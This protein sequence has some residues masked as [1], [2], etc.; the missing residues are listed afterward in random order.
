MKRRLCLHA[1]VAASLCLAVLP[2]AAQEAKP[3]IHVHVTEDGGSSRNI[4][5]NLPLSVVRVALEVAPEKIVE[6][7]RVKLKNGDISIA[8]MRRLWTALRNAGDGEFVNI[9]DGDQY[10]S[11]VREAGLVLIKIDDLD[12]GK[13][14]KVRVEIPVKVVDALFATE[15][16]ELD[17][18]GALDRLHR[19]R[20]DI[21]R[22]IDGDTNVRIWIDETA[23]SS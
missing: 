19:E 2:A 18:A 10:L 22:V 17:I 12:D 20:G 21:I 8:D 4:R 6:K 16:E 7:G 13:D 14:A 1:A 11:I 23:S 5:V 3:W 15:G 9:E